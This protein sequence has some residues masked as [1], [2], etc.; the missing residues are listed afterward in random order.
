MS[1]DIQL[2]SMSPMPPQGDYF[3]PSGGSGPA[4]TAANPLKQFHKLLRGRYPIVI[5]LALIF[6]AAGGAAGWILP[7]PQ[8]MATG[9]I[10][11][12][13]LIRNLND[14]DKVMPMFSAYVNV[15]TQVLASPRLIQAALQRQQ[16]KDTGKPTSSDFVGYFLQNLLIDSP[17]NSQ[18]LTISYTDP[19]DSV[20]SAAGGSLIDAYISDQNDRELKDIATD[21]NTY[22]ARKASAVAGIQTKQALIQTMGGKYGTTDLQ[23]LQNSKLQEMMQLQSQLEQKQADYEAY[24]KGDTPTTKP[25]MAR[26]TAQQLA[27]TNLYVRQL[28]HEA[29][30]ADLDIGEMEIKYG[31]GSQ[32]PQIL[33]LRQKRELCN[34]KI[35][36]QIELYYKHNGL[37]QQN[38]PATNTSQMVNAD[39]FKLQIDSLRQKLEGKRKNASEIAMAAAAIQGYQQEISQMNL[40]IADASKQLDAL[41]FR[42]DMLG[43]VEI[44]NRGDNASPVSNKRPLVA[45]AGLMGGMAI[46]VGLMLLIGLMDSRL[47][48]SDETDT[49]MAGITLLGILP[50][51]P[52]RLSDPEQAATAAHCVHQIRTML[53]I[54]GAATEQSVFAVTSASPGDGQTSLTLALSLSF[55]ACGSRTLL[56]DCDMIG[57]GLTRRLGVASETG[58]L[59]AAATRTVLDHIRT[60]EITDVAILPVGSSGALHASTLS[61]NALRRII[62]EAKKHFDV[63]L[64]DTGPILGSIE[65]SLV[66]TV[67]DGIVLTVARGQHRQII[68][69]SLRHLMSIGAKVAGVVFNRAQARDF[70][71]SLSNVSM[72]SVGLIGTVDAANRYGPLGR[73]VQSSH[74]GKD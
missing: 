21:T 69:K 45:A 70:E 74:K 71:R 29:D 61:P 4:P 9:Q 57:A 27:L 10:M 24:E 44:I 33:A 17:K 66:A 37:L 11:L 28:M 34:Q 25:T 6:G 5:L 50:N 13:P 1:Q 41:V 47:R 64:I 20:A 19:V 15:Q 8:F 23:M 39:E 2:S 62:H 49:D 40:Q 38:D 48:Y 22:E 12:S 7:K 43:R 35:E 42:K 58:I 53:Q 3:P 16:W 30:M 67:A 52:D 60:T 55:A 32:H 14:A 63:I 65:A 18:L 54:N 26:I 72:R 51:L 31:K 56:I 46:P 59:E 68:E 73:A 36:E